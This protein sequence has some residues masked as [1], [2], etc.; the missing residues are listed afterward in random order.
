MKKD[1]WLVLEI[2]SQ[3]SQDV[4]GKKFID[5]PVARDWRRNTGSWIS[6]P[7]VLTAIADEGTSGL[8]DS[9]DQ[10]RP[11]HPSVN[12][13]TRRIPGIWPLVRSW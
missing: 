11:H 1:L 9:A 6:I 5:L 12:S 13:V 7:V 4:A 3:F 10:I 2:C 8:L